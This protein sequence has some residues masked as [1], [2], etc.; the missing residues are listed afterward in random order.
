MSPET[1]GVAR[2]AGTANT[3]FLAPLAVDPAPHD[4]RGG[5]SPGAWPEREATPPGDAAPD[6]RIESDDTPTEPEV[7]V[8]DGAA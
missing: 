7:R 4:P 6:G 1:M 3:P 5:P 2:T 8:T